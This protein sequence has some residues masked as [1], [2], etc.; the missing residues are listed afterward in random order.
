MPRLATIAWR[1]LDTPGREAATLRQ[2]RSGWRLV[3]VAEFEHD[4]ATSCLTYVIKCDR[5]W[6]T[7]EGEITGFVGENPIAVRLERDA[8]GGWMLDGKPASTLNGC[9]DIDLAFSPS[10]NLLPIRR[11]QLRPGNTAH[12]RAAWLRFPELTVEVLEQVYTCLSSNRYLYE[13]ADGAFRRELTIDDV[14]LV[15]DYPGLWIAEPQSV[16]LRDQY[17]AIY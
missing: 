1:R 6:K 4:S 15:V 7:Q 14:G 11:L 2:L 9:V 8:A 16:A 5:R 10:T 13:S 17:D 3:G 12:V